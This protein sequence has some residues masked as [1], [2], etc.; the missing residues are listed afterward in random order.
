MTTNKRQ[1]PP[2]QEATVA[3]IKLFVK[4]LKKRFPDFCPECRGILKEAIN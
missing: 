4:R 3:E 1:Q 2:V